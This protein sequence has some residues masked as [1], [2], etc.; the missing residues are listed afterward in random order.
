MI[1]T[2]NI[3]AP[4]DVGDGDAVTDGRGDD[5]LLDDD[6]VADWLGD[7]VSSRRGT[8]WGHLRPAVFFLIF[9]IK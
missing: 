1:T 3:G 7:Y 9:A 2:V 6:A 8:L 5:I 4:E